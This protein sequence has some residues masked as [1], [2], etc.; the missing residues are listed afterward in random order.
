MSLPDCIV[1]GGRRYLTEHGIPTCDA[2]E[3][4]FAAHPVSN[5]VD[6]STGEAL[7]ICP[8]GWSCRQPWTEAG[9]WA[10]HGAIVEHHRAIR[11]GSVKS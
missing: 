4:V 11:F 1:C 6:P 3:P 2:C 5:Q 7:A 9:R 10:R 8:C